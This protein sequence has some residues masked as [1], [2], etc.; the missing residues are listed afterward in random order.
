M[1]TLAKA[2]LLATAGSLAA[3]AEVLYYTDFSELLAGDADGKVLP[4]TAVFPALSASPDIWHKNSS[5]ATVFFAAGDTTATLST[6]PPGTTGNAAARIGDDT[7]TAVYLHRVLSD[8]FAVD[9]DYDFSFATRLALMDSTAP[10]D[11]SAVG[12]L[13]FSVGYVNADGTLNSFF[14]SAAVTVSDVTAEGWEVGASQLAASAIPADAIGKKIYLRLTHNSVN[15]TGYAVWVDHVQVDA[16]MTVVDSPLLVAMDQLKNHITGTPALTVAQINANAVTIHSNR[17]QFDDSAAIITEAFDLIAT[18]ETVKGP[19]FMNSTTTNGLSRIVTNTVATALANAMLKTQQ[20]V[21][22]I[23]YTSANLAKY[24]GVLNGKKYLTSNA[25]PGAV[26]P[27]ADPNAVY[28]VQ[29]NATQT[30]IWGYPVMFY[31]WPARRPTG[32]YLAPGSVATVTVPPALVNQGF[33]V[34]VGSH[35]NDLSIYHDVTKRIDRISRVYPIASTDTVVANPM[36]GGIYIEVPYP[37]DKG[38]VTVQIKNAVRSPF[39]SNT[40]ARQTT[41]AEW[42]NTERNHPGP[43]VDFETDKMMVNLP[44][45]WIDSALNPVALMADWDQAMDVVSKLCGLP[46]ARSK[47]VLY[48]QVDVLLKANAFTPG[49]PQV[50]AYDPDGAIDAT[51]TAHIWL[52]GPRLADYAALH[53][54]GHACL[55]TKFAGE[56]EATVNFIN[57]AVNNRVYG[58]DLDEAFGRSMG[59]AG[60][61]NVTRDQAAL[62]WILDD[63]FRAGLFM[64]ADDMKYQ[65]RGYA[66]YA[67]I[68]ALFGWDAIDNFWHSVGVDY[69]DGI[70]YET[71]ADPADSRILRMSRVAGADLTPL[72]HFWGVSPQNSTTLKTKMLNEGLKPSATIYDRLKHY[73]SIVP[74]NAAE[75][76]VHAN[77]VGGAPRDVAWYDA[78]KTG[79]TQAMGTTSVYRVQ[80]IIDTYFPTGRPIEVAYTNAVSTNAVFY[81]DFGSAALAADADGKLVLTTDAATSGDASLQ[82]TNPGT[83]YTSAASSGYTIN[84]ESCAVANSITPDGT[85]TAALRVGFATSGIGSVNYAHMAVTNRFEAGKNH[86]LSTAAR[87][88]LGDG[89]FANAGEFGTFQLQCGYLNEAN[90]VVWFGLAINQAN[91]SS[92][93]WTTY[94]KTVL[95]ADIPAAAIGRPIYFSVN[96]PAVNTSSYFTWLDHIRVE[97]TTGGEIVKGADYA[98]WAKTAFV[99]VPANVN[100]TLA[101]NPDGDRYT[102]EQE[103]ALVI[104]PL[105]AGEPAMDISVDPSSFTVGYLRRFSS[106]YNVGAIW[107]YSLTQPDW[108]TDNMA[109]VPVGLDGDVE[110]M[111]ATV[112]LDGTNKFI[113]IEASK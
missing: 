9:T 45:R 104:D 39:Y 97:S 86:I 16:S 103:W 102:N 22:D 37:A 113:R 46:L 2:I 8:V 64:N 59:N 1:N 107:T 94:S 82:A 105:M 57:V 69:M 20:A 93:G 56:S 88:A 38:L 72:I 109:D 95:A 29:I 44:K 49:Y 108:R 42:Q 3:S 26:A 96:H 77:L 75:F 79:W 40:S 73:Q 55:L 53:E 54:L 71:N 41:L 78:M 13:A 58:I 50:I 83:W 62:L 48:G 27:P 51:D 47:T 80:R 112:P 5:A 90:V 24:T 92:T 36:G 70:E 7:A 11:L 33:S 34:R 101:G 14:S 67:E 23:V 65:H 100:R 60:C 111:E 66:K 84:S 25:F 76:T 31:D 63:K 35:V 18:Y 10:E 98:G 28:S 89:T 19:L 21:L 6:P 52:T 87:I 43:W 17:G 81:T 12:R 106:G 61:K 99:E 32:A 110:L 15:S 85:T 74:M 91:V 4:P 68:A 30:P